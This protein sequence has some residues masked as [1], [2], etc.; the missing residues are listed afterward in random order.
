MTRKEAI[1]KYYENP[2]K[3]LNCLKPIPIKEGRTL[4]ETR[5][6][7]FCSTS[8]AGTYNGHKFPKK[9]KQGSCGVCEK[10]ITAHLVYCS[11]ECRAIAKLQKPKKTTPISRSKNVVSWRQRMKVKSLEYKGGR[12][13]RCG[14]D[15]CVNAMDFHHIDPAQKGFPIASRIR[16]WEK[17]K[18]ELD[19]CVLLCSNCHRE[20]HGG[21]WNLEEVIARW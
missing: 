3:C 10:E 11:K 1:E 5:K 8:C 17:L 9:K 16:S 15:R 21:I 2:N 12:C 19:K 4:S 18:A 6:K 14:Y 20:F 7:K 13:Q